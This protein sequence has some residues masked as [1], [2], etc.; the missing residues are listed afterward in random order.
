MKRYF[1]W[2][3]I[4]F[5][6]TQPVWAESRT[7]VLTIPGMSC[8]ACPLT[9]KMALSRIAGV[10]GMTFNVDSRQ[11]IVQFDAAKTTVEALLRAT[12]DASYPATLK[13]IT[14]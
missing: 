4:S 2:L 10:T 12:G 11:A 6:M 9:I 3:M 14:P 13:E 8:G 5:A 7:A 1:A